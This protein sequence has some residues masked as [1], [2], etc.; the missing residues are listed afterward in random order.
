MPSSILDVI[1]LLFTIH[2]RRCNSV[3]HIFWSDM[4]GCVA[5][6]L[7]HCQSFFNGL[8]F[9]DRC[10]TSAN[11]LEQSSVSW[12]RTFRNSLQGDGSWLW[13]KSQ[14]VRRSSFQNEG[15]LFGCLEGEVDKRPQV[16][17]RVIVQTAEREGWGLHFLLKFVEVGQ[18]YERLIKP[19]TSKWKYKNYKTTGKNANRKIHWKHA[20][21]WLGSSLEGSLIVCIWGTLFLGKN[22]LRLTKPFS[23]LNMLDDLFLSPGVFQ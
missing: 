10:S 22:A 14:Y 4:P 8:L 2:G 11:T 3:W 20:F 9:M 6:I 23:T 18:R 17:G 1:A 7:Q 21:I 15:E 16:S 12:T 5:H 19:R 13:G